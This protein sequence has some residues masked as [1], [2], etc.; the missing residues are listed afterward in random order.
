MRIGSFDRPPPERQGVGC[1]LQRSG[2]PHRYYLLPLMSEP[3]CSRVPIELWQQILHPLFFLDFGETDTPLRQTWRR[4]KTHCD[5][6]D[7]YRLLYAVR[8]RLR[9][10]NRC[11]NELVDQLPL[12][13]VRLCTSTE[14][15]L[16]FKSISSSLTDTPLPLRVMPLLRRH[17]IQTL[18]LECEARSATH[19]FPEITR[20]AHTLPHLRVLYVRLRRC[21]DNDA[22][23]LIVPLIAALAQNLVSLR[24]SVP[25]LTVQ[26]RSAL[27]FP[28][29]RRLRVDCNAGLS[30]SNLGV[31]HWNLP[32]IQWLEIPMLSFHSSLDTT[33]RWEAQLQ[34]LVLWSTPTFHT[35][36]MWTRLPALRTVK[37]RMSPILYAS[38]LPRSDSSI[39]EL[40]VCVQVRSINSSLQVLETFTGVDKP[41][42][43]ILDTTHNSS[44]AHRTP[45][46]GRKI[47]LEGVDWAAPG[48]LIEDI[49]NVCARWERIAPFL[50]DECGVSWLKAKT[51]FP[52]FK[53]KESESGTEAGE[54]STSSLAGGQEKSSCRSK[55]VPRQRAQ[56]E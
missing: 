54:A 31:A 12:T 9:L 17:T 11:W 5:I 14:S 45:V 51:C 50:E 36:T 18:S 7:G 20:N 53:R 22:A 33:P 24:I 15:T 1:G 16:S 23:R 49:M 28:N 2:T 48:P 55:V 29:L 47:I 25:I 8:A 46:D 6:A 41:R 21:S 3:A 30:Y 43:E 10:V 39:R 42:R 44:G 27:Q 26:T 32:S 56:F 4:R 19:I 40:V 37:V 34:T 35:N 38:L 13:W 52:H